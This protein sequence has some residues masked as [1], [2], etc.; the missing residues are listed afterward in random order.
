MEME[1]YLDYKKHMNTH[2]LIINKTGIKSFDAFNNEGYGSRAVL[3]CSLLKKF[4]INIINSIDTHFAK[5]AQLNKNDAFVYYINKDEDD[6]SS[7]YAE[8]IVNMDVCYKLG[9]TEQEQLAAVAHEVGH[10]IIYFREDKES[11]SESM[12]ELECD[13]YACKMGL[14]KPLSS[15]LNKMYDSHLYSKEQETLFLKR[16]LYIKPVNTM[17]L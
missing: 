11:L 13:L 12:E 6:A 14:S 7:T 1:I 5:V 3:L 17:W 10:I 4:Q 15:L 9:L 16:L 8:I 2:Q